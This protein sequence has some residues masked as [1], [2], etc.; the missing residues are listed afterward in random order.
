MSLYSNV[1][2]GSLTHRDT[3]RCPDSRTGIYLLQ[4][5]SKYSMILPWYHVYKSCYVHG[6][7]TSLVERQ[8]FSCLHLTDEQKID[9]RMYYLE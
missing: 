4:R 9:L 3:A 5:N 7:R 1:T 8:L 6:A 2:Y